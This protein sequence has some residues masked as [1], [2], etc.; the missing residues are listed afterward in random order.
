MA[1]TVAAAP[2][3]SEAAASMAAE[4]AASMASSSATMASSSA[5]MA[6]SSSASSASAAIEKVLVGTQHSLSLGRL[7]PLYT[8][9][10]EEL[11][12]WCQA[13]GCHRACALRTL[14]LF[15]LARE[16]A[17]DETPRELAALR[18]LHGELHRRM[19]VT[20]RPDAPEQGL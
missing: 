19:A 2:T 14:R 11:E 12:A 7:Q 20:A 8:R 16:A 1:A 15:D 18:A 9:P 6:S 17:G 13:S 4:A 5:S 10:D 3:A